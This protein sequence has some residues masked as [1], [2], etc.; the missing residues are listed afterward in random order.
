MMFMIRYQED[1]CIYIYMYVREYTLHNYKLFILADLWYPTSA[2]SD[3]R[4]NMHV[5]QLTAL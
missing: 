2:L 5:L 4:L 3:I 1:V